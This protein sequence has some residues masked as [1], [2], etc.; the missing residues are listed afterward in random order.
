VD[1]IKTVEYHENI[2]GKGELYLEI[3]RNG[4]I[5]INLLKVIGK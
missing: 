1:R 5:R 2:L 4:K 3:L